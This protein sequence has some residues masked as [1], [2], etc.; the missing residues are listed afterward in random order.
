MI[1]F[2]LEMITSIPILKCVSYVALKVNFVGSEGH[3]VSGPFSMTIK[4][5]LGLIVTYVYVECCVM[6][7]A[8]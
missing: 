2:P 1:R 3:S 6:K 5:I 8:S 4:L 7:L